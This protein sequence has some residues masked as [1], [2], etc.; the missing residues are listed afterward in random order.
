MLGMRVPT[1][2]SLAMRSARA[3]LLAMGVLPLA[4]SLAR[5]LSPVACLA[6]RAFSGR[7][8]RAQR[9]IN[10]RLPGQRAGDGLADLR[11]EAL[12]LGDVDELA[13]VVGARLARAAVRV[14]GLD[15]LLDE[16]GERC[17]LLVLG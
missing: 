8:R 14:G 10:R 1:G 15:R 12:E 3:V 7:L 5:R 6:Y 11:T 4:R 13:A 9:L 2:V 16:A 17:H